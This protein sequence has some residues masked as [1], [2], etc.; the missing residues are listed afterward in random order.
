MVSKPRAST[1]S[2]SSSVASANA[3]N[4][5]SAAVHHFYHAIV[6]GRERAVALAEVRIASARAAGSSRT[7]LV[8]LLGDLAAAH[9]GGVLAGSPT[10]PAPAP[11]SSSAADSRA[12][13]LA[14]AL[15]LIHPRD[16]WDWRAS[17]PA[18]LAALATGRASVSSMSFGI[19]RNSS[20][21][22]LS[23]PLAAASL[24]S[25][26]PSTSSS[27]LLDP[28]E[29][30]VRLSVGP[31]KGTV[32]SLAEMLSK[33]ADWFIATMADFG[34][35]NAKALSAL[36][37]DP[38]AFG[39][40]LRGREGQ[41]G[42]RSAAKLN[43]QLRAFTPAW[44]ASDVAT[45]METCSLSGFADEEGRYLSC[46]SAAARGSGGGVSCDDGD[47]DGDDDSDNATGVDPSDVDDEDGED[48]DDEW[49]RV[50]EGG[51]GEGEEAEGERR[52]GT[53]APRRQRQRRR[54][55]SST[56]P[57]AAPA[58]ASSLPSRDELSVVL[59]AMCLSAEQRR[60]VV[61][62]RRDYLR[63]RRAAAQSRAGALATLRGL[64]LLAPQ[65][66]RNA[67]KGDN[68]TDDS[69]YNNN[70][71]SNSTSNRSSR[72][73]SSGT[74]NDIGRGA[75]ARALAASAA[76]SAAAAADARA[77]TELSIRVSSMVTRA[78]GAI[79]NGLVYPRA[80]CVSWFAELVAEQAGEPPAE[81]ILS[82][83]VVG[84]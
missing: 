83:A 54:P 17:T 14:R 51:E 40:W 2:S 61:E 44:A 69:E 74:A 66:K 53:S 70:Q 31:S 13:V 43:S 24:S 67:V 79:Y 38:A 75:Y 62:L 6:N 37:R 63:A 50:S 64:L 57:P 72:R 56:A 84:T 28:R 4:S 26:S 21:S 23:S 27:S 20:I 10:P 16:E 30:R 49:T 3:A 15:D 9:A 60:G 33:P 78:Q 8:E 80:H 22:S 39:E 11:P 65:E 35:S 29:L 58:P 18:A 59:E 32:V 77:E 41:S 34:A 82:G 5:A 76:L 45:A 12:L 73:G 52:G 25:P 7:R 1:S 71:N 42:L 81:A 36:R 19:S 46:S 47:D 68:N 48:V 55:S